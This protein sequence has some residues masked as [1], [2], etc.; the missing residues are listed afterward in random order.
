ML[1]M[2]DNYDSF[3]YNLV[4]YLEELG[5]RVKVVRNDKITLD[6]MN[7]PRREKRFIYARHEAMYLVARDCSR[8]SYPRIGRMFD[9]DH[10]TIIFGIRAH[11]KRSGLPRA[12]E[13]VAP[14]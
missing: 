10:T 14:V 12:R 5:V 7:S 6:E 4:Q 3:T 11:A 8:L 9:R 13:G 2:I 1:L